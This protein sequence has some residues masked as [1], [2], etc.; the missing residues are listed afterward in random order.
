[1]KQECV[2]RL[3][4]AFFF[5]SRFLLQL[6]LDAVALQRRQVFDEDLALEVIH[7]VLDADGQQLVGIEFEGLPSASKAR[8]F[9]RAGRSTPS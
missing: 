1:M 9:T 8:T 7:L 2:R 5:I 3:Q 6:G 4:P